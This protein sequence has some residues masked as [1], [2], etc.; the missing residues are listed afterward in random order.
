MFEAVVFLLVLTVILFCNG[1]RFLLLRVEKRSE[2]RLKLILKN[3]Q[4]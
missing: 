1:M 4:S 3:L 2:G